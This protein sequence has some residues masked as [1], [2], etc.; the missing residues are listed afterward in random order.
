[1]PVAAL[2]WTAM[3]RRIDT[4]PNESVRNRRIA[5]AIAACILTATIFIS[6]FIMARLPPAVAPVIQTEVTMSNADRVLVVSPH[7]DDE[8]IACSGL[9]QHALKAGARVR[10][11]WMTAGDHNV[12]GPPLFW[13]KVA[14]T[15]AQ[16]QD[17]G[18]RRIQEARS[19]AQVLGLSS[20]DLMF[21]GYPDGGLSDIFMNVWTS[22]PYRSGLTNAASVPY[23]ESAVA[24]QPQTAMNLLADLE[25]VMT[26]F[27]PTIVAYPNLIDDHPDHQATGLFVS[28]ALADLGLS[29]RRLEYVVHIKGWP[30][31]L[32]YAPFVDAYAPPAAR[33][34]GLSQEVI[35]LT[36]Q[37]VGI[38]TR[39]IKAHASELL[40]FA[41]LVAFARRTEVFLAPADL[42][43]RTDA[44]RTAQFFFP[45]AHANDEDRP[46]VMQVMVAY[47]SDG[48]VL[49]LEMGRALNRLE[50][51]ELFLFPLPAGSGFGSAPKLHVIYRGGATTA[52]VSDL[53][54]PTADRATARVG[55][56]GTTV[57]LTFND[58]LTGGSTPRLG[59]KGSGGRPRGFFLRIE[60]G[61]GR[62]DI[63]RSRTVWIGITPAVP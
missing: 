3:M 55:H 34:L 50:E 8:S 28:A 46:V 22:K 23:A 49:T 29:P 10:V 60:K 7:P 39:A 63:T 38:K 15:P 19:A 13:R 45:V 9:I 11:L 53:G 37:E 52:E 48:L 4:A 33:V 42:N 51:M 12:V 62:V 17:I 16:F 32:R 58:T 27:Q 2:E 1:M 35:H 59:P 43:D 26:S 57:S 61:P 56:D 14:V 30:R 21:L 54:H 20:E 25:H 47:G 31:P 40:P 41:T 18:H 36:P 6:A 5:T 24:G 44:V